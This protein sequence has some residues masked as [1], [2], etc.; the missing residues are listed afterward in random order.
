[1]TLIFKIMLLG[2]SE[3]IFSLAK[4]NRILLY[5]LKLDINK[6]RVTQ[7][8]NILMSRPLL[9]LILLIFVYY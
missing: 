1:M 2:W 7:V 5:L 3:I 8:E 9:R 4:L 6:K